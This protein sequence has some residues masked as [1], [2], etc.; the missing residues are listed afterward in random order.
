MCVGIG[1]LPLVL[2]IKKHCCVCWDWYAA[3]GPVDKKNTAVC[4]GIG[5]LPLVPIIGIPLL[6]YQYQDTSRVQK[7]GTTSIDEPSPPPTH[8]RKKEK[9]RER[10]KKE[11]QNR[12]PNVNN[13][14][15]LKTKYC[16]SH[17]VW[18]NL[19]ILTWKLTQIFSVQTLIP[20]Y[21]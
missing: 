4:V 12:W 13:Q 7:S 3:P 16:R 5:M 11:I 18:A 19:R 9:N 8:L 15:K 14:K 21:G 2:W 1:M 20:L 6:L 10:W 17:L